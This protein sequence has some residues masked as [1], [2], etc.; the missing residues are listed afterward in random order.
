MKY[1]TIFKKQLNFFMGAPT[2]ALTIKKT[3]K[4]VGN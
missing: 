1:E 4:I 2:L 3:K